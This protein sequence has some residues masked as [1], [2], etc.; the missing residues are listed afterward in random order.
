M[1][2]HKT[3]I[4]KRSRIER[5]RNQSVS[6]AVVHRTM[7]GAPT[8]HGHSGTKRDASS[9]IR[10]RMA[11]Y[12]RQ[13]YAATSAPAAVNPMLRNIARSHTYRCGPAIRL[14]AF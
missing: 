14:F 13:G 8:T 10:G 12:F 1:Y 5:R 11:S 9:M 7:I 3:T 4:R 6:S 2:A